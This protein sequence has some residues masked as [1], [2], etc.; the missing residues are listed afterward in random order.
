MILRNSTS[1]AVSTLY[2]HS[3]PPT[4][5]RAGIPTRTPLEFQPFLLGHQYVDTST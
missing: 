2:F 4:G 3:A 1:T 5:F